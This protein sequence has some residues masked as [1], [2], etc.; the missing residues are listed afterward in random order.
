MHGQL[1]VGTYMRGSNLD[2]AV[3]RVHSLVENSKFKRVHSRVEN[4]K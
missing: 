4:S 2:G 3:K 1:N